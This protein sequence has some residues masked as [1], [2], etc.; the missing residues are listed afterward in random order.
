MAKNSSLAGKSFS[1]PIVIENV[2]V[3]GS[4]MSKA[5]AI[6]SDAFRSAN[7]ASAMEIPAAARQGDGV[8]R[9][10]ERERGRLADP[11][12]CPRDYRDL[13]R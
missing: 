10:Q 2:L 3:T 1:T 13:V 5:G 6:T 9:M 12:A 11:R 8:P 4:P 7:G